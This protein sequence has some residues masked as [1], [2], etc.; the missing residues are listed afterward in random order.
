[1]FSSSPFDA[2]DWNDFPV[3][4]DGA[5]SFQKFAAGSQGLDSQTCQ[6]SWYPQNSYF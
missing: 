3:R 4:D 5:L 2:N 1:M 6:D